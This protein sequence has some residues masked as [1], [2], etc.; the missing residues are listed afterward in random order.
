MF[1]EQFNVPRY[2]LILYVR[3]LLLLLSIFILET[4]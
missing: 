4:F 2:S 3:H 1:F